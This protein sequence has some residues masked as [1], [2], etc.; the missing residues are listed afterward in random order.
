MKISP[1]N[2][3]NPRR[4]I[5]ESPIKIN[6]LRGFLVHSKLKMLGLGAGYGFAMFAAL[7]LLFAVYCYIRALYV[8]HKSK[9]ERE[10]QIEFAAKNWTLFKDEEVIDTQEVKDGENQ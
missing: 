10:Q 9:K 6:S 4:I 5:Y 1:K 3:K 2:E 8:G 7:S